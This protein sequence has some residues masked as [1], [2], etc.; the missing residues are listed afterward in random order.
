MSQNGNH[1]Q[2]EVGRKRVLVVGAG[3]AGYVH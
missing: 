1:Q 3:A 2:S